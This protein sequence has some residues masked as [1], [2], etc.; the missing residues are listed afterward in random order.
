MKPI[1]MIIA[2]EEPAEEGEDLDSLLED[3]DEGPEETA[4]IQAPEDTQSGDEAGEDLDS[5]LDDLDEEPEEPA[6]TEAAGDADEDE[7]AQ[8]DPRAS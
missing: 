2:E 3:L 4:E 7:D 8:Q 5:L 1:R 6:D